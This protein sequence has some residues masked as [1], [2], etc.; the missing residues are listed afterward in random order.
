MGALKLTY[1]TGSMPCGSACKFFPFNKHHIL[2]AILGKVIGNR[3]AMDS[4]ANDNNLR[5]F[6]KG[7]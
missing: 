3:T 6:W 4:A 1:Q 5:M 2:P 7:C